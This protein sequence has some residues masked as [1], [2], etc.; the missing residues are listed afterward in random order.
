MNAHQT[1]DKYFKILLDS[2]IVS[3]SDLNGNIICVNDN[4]VDALGFTK[5]EIIGRNHN[6]L[7]HPSTPDSVFKELWD[8]IK[9]GQVFRE[10]VLSR[11]KDGSDFWAETTIIPLVDDNNDTIIEFI[12]IRKDITEFLYM[13]RKI[14]QQQIQEEKQKVISKAKDDFL[15]LFTHELKTPLNTI[16]NFSQY[17]YKNADKTSL[18]KELKLLTQIIHNSKKMLVD[19]TQLL[20]L[21]KLKSNKLHYNFSHFP[22]NQAINEELSK[23]IS[24]ANEHKVNIRNYIF[25]KNIYI[26][27]DFYRFSQIIAN[28]LSNAIKYSNGKVALHVD[29]F[30]DH[31]ELTIEDNGIGV[32]DKEKIFELFEQNNDNMNTRGKKGTGIGL[33]F[34]KFLCKDLKIDYRIEDSENLGGLKFILKVKTIGAR[35]D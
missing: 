9:S 33:S 1:N 27:S 7:R 34:V 6:I 4:F 10:R 28:V 24:L 26:K 31:I 23:H 16:I 32:V 19:V 11:K 8:T 14:Q 5:E 25:D 29:Q 2:S 13:Q 15:V 18:E 12:A 21:N 3:K 17:L 30:K 20:E 22:I 35:N